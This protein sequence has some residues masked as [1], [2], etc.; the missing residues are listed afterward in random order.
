MIELYFFTPT[1]EGPENQTWV[2]Q[3][4]EIER[5]AGLEK[6]QPVNPLPPCQANPTTAEKPKLPKYTIRLLQY[7]NL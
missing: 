6:E 7:G 1:P 2:Q 3:K 5:F 4:P